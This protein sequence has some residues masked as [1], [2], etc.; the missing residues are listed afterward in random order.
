[1]RSRELGSESAPTHARPSSTT[2]C[3][4][5][6]GEALSAGAGAAAGASVS[7]G[8]AAAAADDNDD[9]HTIAP[10]AADDADACAAWS[11]AVEGLA[12]IAFD[13]SNAN[14]SS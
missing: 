6:G 3:V 8:L 1:M 4:A 12:A 2:L 10:V 13:C 7:G 11:V 9:D 5:L 14:T